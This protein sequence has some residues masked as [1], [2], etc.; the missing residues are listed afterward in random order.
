MREFVRLDAQ[1]KMLAR[2]LSLIF[3]ALH[4]ISIKKQLP[5]ISSAVCALIQTIR[6]FIRQIFSCMKYNLSVTLNYMTET[7]AT[8]RIIKMPGRRSAPAH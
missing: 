5:C 1:I 8:W 2:Q 6:L 4:V 7:N 3:L